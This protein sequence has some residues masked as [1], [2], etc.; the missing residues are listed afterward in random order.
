MDDAYVGIGEI[1]R[2]DAGRSYDPDGSVKQYFFDFGDGKTSGWMPE[3]YAYHDYDSSGTYTAR[4]RVKDDSYLESGWSNSVTVHVDQNPP[5]YDEN[6]N[7]DYVSISPSNPDTLPATCR[8]PIRTATSTTSGSAGK[9]TAT[10]RGN[11]GA[12]FLAPT[13]P[14]PRPWTTASRAPA[15]T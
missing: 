7:I 13:I 4:V 11:T 6:P 2:F 1:V 14:P 8:C 12:K 9:S 10:W 15:T 3:P 5:V